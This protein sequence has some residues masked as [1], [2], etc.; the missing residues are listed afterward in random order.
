MLFVVE[1][2]SAEC[3]SLV[4][5]NAHNTS[6]DTEFLTKLLTLFQERCKLKGQPERDGWTL[7]KPSPDPQHYLKVLCM[8]RALSFMALMKTTQNGKH[9]P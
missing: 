6:L 1:L 3:R 5:T 2:E 8:E 4:L 7:R 9:C